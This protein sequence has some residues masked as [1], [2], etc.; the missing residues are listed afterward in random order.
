M[1]NQ[2]SAAY[3]PVLLIQIFENFLPNISNCLVNYAPRMS[4][5][6]AI[7]RLESVLDLQRK[8]FIQNPLISIEE[9]KTNIKKI[10]EMVLNHKDEIREALN[11][12][13]AS[14]P[15]AVS[16]FVEVLGVVARA[17]Y[18]ISK[19]DEWTASEFRDVDP[20]MFGKSKG[21]I[22]YQPK[23]VVGN[24]VRKYKKGSGS[25]NTTKIPSL[26]LSD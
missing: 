9:R 26:E 3:A 4:D 16:D 22:R 1:L 12:D 19:I 2:N 10:P 11:Q 5:H 21:E 24:I 15:A 18:V 14:H 25:E 23:G 7:T 8:A 20:Q 13:F 17:S 6:E